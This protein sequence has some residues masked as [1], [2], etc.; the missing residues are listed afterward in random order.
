MAAACKAIAAGFPAAVCK[1]VTG[2]TVV[3]TADVGTASFS[4]VLSPMP[5]LPTIKWFAGGTAIA[6][7][8]GGM[9]TENIV[10]MIMASLCTGP[11][12]DLC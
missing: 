8:T 3:N 5:S 2:D 9:L 4:P 12:L 7:G 10:A 6:T 11:I 1:T